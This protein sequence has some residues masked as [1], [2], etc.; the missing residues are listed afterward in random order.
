MR[1][2]QVCPYDWQAPGGVQTHVRSLATELIRRGHE[3]AVAAPAS[4]SPVDPW[5]RVVGTPVGIPFNGTIAPVCATFGSVRAVAD[6]L[7]TF[8]PDLVHT[9]EPFAPSIGAFAGMLS[10][11][12]VVSTFHANCDV[13]VGPW[14]YGIGTYFLNRHVA[15]SIAVSA[16][17]MR[18]LGPRCRVPIRIIPNG[19]DMPP[20]SGHRSV[21]ASPPQLLFAHRLEPRKGFRVALAAFERLAVTRPDLQLIVIGDGVDRHAIDS[22]RPEVRARVQMRGVVSRT[23]LID[24]LRSATVFLATA[25]NGESFGIVLLEAL[26]AGVPVVASD[27]DGYRELL[28][29]D[30]G[31]IIVPPN[32][33]AAVATTVAGILD[34]AD[35]YGRLQAA[36]RER[37]SRYSWIRVTDEV[38]GLYDQVIAASS[39]HRNLP[40]IWSQLKSR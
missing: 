4:T 20:T 38:T 9:H 22:L 32:D 25:V 17:A 12:P 15:A 31:G 40:A 24:T 11:A 35:S 2:L 30:G 3:V 37:A 19:V 8:A 1:I 34:T 21:S 14:L 10:R 27:V 7:R 6:V 36:A 23:E 13:R 39:R 18:C 26:A 16:V 28:A 33:P 5:V 29:G